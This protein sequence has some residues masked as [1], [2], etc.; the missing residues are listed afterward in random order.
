MARIIIGM[1]TSLDGYINDRNGKVDL[2]YPDMEGMRESPELQALIART[3]AV[4]M[5]RNTYDMAGGD[6][7]GYE[8]QVPIF[9]VTHQQPE[10]T[11]KGENEQLRFHF[12]TDGLEAAVTQAKAAAGDKDVVVVGG[13]NI[14]QQLVRARLFDEIHVDVQP[15][16]LGG[17]TRLF[18]DIGPEPIMLTPTSLA[19]P[20]GTVHL[21]F[22][23]AAG[24]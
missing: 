12:V 21:R 1:V 3:G 24:G 23:R 22:A 2:L 15:V 9:V 18:G 7:T 4:L 11:A 5:G 16:L 10:Q 17:G 19:G 14:N 13:A 8:L 6:Y 20:L